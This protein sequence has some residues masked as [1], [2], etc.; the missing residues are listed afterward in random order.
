GTG[1]EGLA[2]Q[3]GAGLRFLRAD[4]DA[5]LL[6]LV[7]GAMVVFANM[8]VVAEV[9]FAES[10]L[11]RAPPGTP[12]WSRPGPPA[13]SPGRWPAAGCPSTASQ[14][15]AAATA[16]S[17]PATRNTGRG[18]PPSADVAVPTSTTPTGSMARNSTRTPL[19]TR[20]SIARGTIRC[21][22][23]RFTRLAT[24]TAPV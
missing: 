1:R 13:C 12:C 9:A 18:S 21:R 24:T 3:L 11:G 23:V 22:W 15:A 2:A 5:G 7:V 17:V 20:P 19:V 10:V 16:V 8:A 4:A 6:V 14:P